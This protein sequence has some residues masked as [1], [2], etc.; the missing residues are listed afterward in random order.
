LS[1][2]ERLVCVFSD[3]EEADRA[4]AAYYGALTPEQRLDLLLT[5][6]AR[7]RESLGATAEGFER[8]CRVVDLAES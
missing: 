5:L 8:V 4:D 3:A 2:V 1:T 6:I 7:H